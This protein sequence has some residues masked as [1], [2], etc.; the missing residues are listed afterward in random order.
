MEGLQG[1]NSLLQTFSILNHLC[2]NCCSEEAGKGRLPRKMEHPDHFQTVGT[3]LQRLFGSW[4]S[5]VF[6]QPSKNGE[7]YDEVLT[8]LLLNYCFLLSYLS[9]GTLVLFGYADL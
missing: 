8:F 5:N 1:N 6:F 2:C 3:L 4:T 7:D 9:A